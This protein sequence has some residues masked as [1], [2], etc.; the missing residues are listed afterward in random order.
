MKRKNK[1]HVGMSFSA[2]VSVTDANKKACMKKIG[3]KVTHLVI[4]VKVGSQPLH[5]K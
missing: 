1:N 4:L 5:K 2:I 3:E